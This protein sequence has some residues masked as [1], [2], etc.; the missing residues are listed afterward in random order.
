VAAGDLVLVGTDSG[1]LVALAALDGSR[2]YQVKTGGPI[3][4][5]PAVAGDN[6]WFTSYDGLLRVA[7]PATGAERW[8]F[9]AKGQLYSSPAV[10]GQTAFFGSLSGPFYAATWTAE[11]GLAVE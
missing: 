7:D 11:P 4:C 3:K 6:L 1:N 5:R 8:R 9:Q 10:L 2:R